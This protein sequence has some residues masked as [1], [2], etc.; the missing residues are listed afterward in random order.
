MSTI[1][2][3]DTFP[4][5]WYI[6]DEDVER[7]KEFFTNVPTTLDPNILIDGMKDSDFRYYCEMMF[8]KLDDADNVL[9][10][11]EKVMEYIYQ[12]AWEIG[13]Q[14]V[15]RYK[16]LRQVQKFLL[17]VIDIYVLMGKANFRGIQVS[18]LLVGKE[19]PSIEI[20]IDKR[21]E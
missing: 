2:L 18:S 12:F 20:K 9:E 3:D 10:L 11:S 13:D 8:G 16:Y 5:T 6:C 15:E 14:D 4:I 1:Q 21:F 17:T 7:Y 19:D